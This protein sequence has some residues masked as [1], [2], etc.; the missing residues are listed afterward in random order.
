MILLKGKYA[1]G[2]VYSDVREEKG[3]NQIQLLLNQP[4][5]EGSHPRFMPD[6]H[7]GLG[8][9]IGTTMFVTDEI[10]PNLVGVDIGCGIRT[11]R[12]RLSGDIDLEVLDQWIRSSI[13]SGFNV[14][15]KERQMDY[16]ERLAM[17]RHIKDASRLKKSLGTL[18]GGNH[19]IEIGQGEQG[20]EYILTVHSGSRNLG[21]QVAE[22]YQKCA[23]KQSK[24][25]KDQ[26]QGQ[27]RKLQRDERSFFGA[28]Q[29]WERHQ[30]AIN[31]P[32][33]LETLHRG[34]REYDDYLRD[35]NI[36][37]E[38]AL[39]NRREMAELLLDALGAERIQ[40]F[41]TIHNYIE[42]RPE[43][44]PHILRKGAVSAQEGEL[45]T[46]PLNMRDGN[47]ICRGLG[48]PEWNYS[49]PHGAGRLMS[50]SQARK[51]LKLEDFH[52]TME[53]IFTTSISQRTLD[54]APFA[55]KPM[56]DIIRFIGDTVEILQL[57]R[58]I[59]NFKAN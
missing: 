58:P 16:I 48:N 20:D 38:F 42:R 49:A 51:E 45:L 13:P 9:V 27:A 46:I 14:H 3:I 57:V 17:Q 55:Y 47:L 10:C 4:F 36:C 56:E 24:F 15:S 21:L 6:Y 2:I 19:Y 29:E 33:G 30:D 12:F 41:D 37:V 31:Q 54:E 52:R 39:E 43:G 53:G 7:A 18:G 25:R 8:S 59:Y 11:E 40:G 35:M 1:E 26:F 32:K 50:R 28:Q 44:N 22:Y 23:V 5:T 34:T